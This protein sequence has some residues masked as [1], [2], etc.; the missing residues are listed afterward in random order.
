MFS[1]TEYLPPRYSLKRKKSSNFAVKKLG[2]YHLI[3][4]LKLK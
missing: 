2:E 4:G 3:K 1:V